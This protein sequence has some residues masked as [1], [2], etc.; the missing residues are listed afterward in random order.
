MNLKIKNIITFCL[1]GIAAYMATDIIHEVIGH[2]GTC[3]IIGQKIKLLTSVYFKSK[4]GSVL[5]DL[6]GPGSNLLFGFLIFYILKQNKN[7]PITLSLLL[8]LTMIYNFYWFSGTI[9]QSSF[10]KTGDFTYAVKQLNIGMLGKF[11]LIIGGLTS[12]YFT[13]RMNKTHFDKINILFPEFPL[14]QFV[15]YSY[16]AAA[17]SATIAGLFFFN[18]SIR[19]A[20]EGLME[21][22]ASLPII[23]IGSKNNLKINVYNIKSNRITFNLIV[24]ILYILFCFT[25]GRGFVM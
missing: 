22:I 3:L 1:I 12:Y 10:S 18:G 11:I 17:V 6:G 2:S 8:T 15:Y 7:I 19:A 21:M 16:I 14:K 25:L 13:I 24:I 5:T 20:H 23:F 4:P 9:L